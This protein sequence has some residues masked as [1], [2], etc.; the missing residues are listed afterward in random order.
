MSWQKKIFLENRVF[1]QLKKIIIKFQWKLKIVKKKLDLKKN[2]WFEKKKFS[3]FYWTNFFFKFL[4]KKF[5]FQIFIK[6]FFF[7]LAFLAK[8]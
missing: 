2:Y 8:I 7:I 5:F 1:F 6:N 4:L 3:D